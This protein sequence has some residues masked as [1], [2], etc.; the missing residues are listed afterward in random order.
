MYV[1]SKSVFLKLWKGFKVIQSRVV[2]L[3]KKLVKWPTDECLSK[4]M[5]ISRIRRYVRRFSEI[6]TIFY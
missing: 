5:Y 4:D 2:I 1:C 3:R 6:E